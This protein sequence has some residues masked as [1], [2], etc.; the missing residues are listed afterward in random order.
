[1]MSERERVDPRRGE[2]GTGP[3]IPPGER[4][5]RRSPYQSRELDREPFHRRPEPADYRRDPA[6]GPV[7]SDFRGPP[8]ENFRPSEYRPPHPDYHREALPPD[9]PPQRRD[10]H[11][12]PPDLRRDDYS[13]PP[14]SHGPP[15]PPQLRSDYRP[16]PPPEHRAQ[17]YRHELP[18]RPPPDYRR[19][20]GPAD[21]RGPPG[22]LPPPGEYIRQ[23]PPP[24]QEFKGRESGEILPPRDYP[25][26]DREREHLRE[27]DYSRPPVGDYPRRR[28]EDFMIRPSQQPG[29]LPPGPGIPG[30]AS[31]PSSEMYAKHPSERERDRERERWEQKERE[32]NGDRGHYPP[33]SSAGSNSGHPPP[34]HHHSHSHTHP[35]P[36]PHHPHHHPHHHHIIHQHQQHGHNALQHPSPP[37]H[38]TGP[39]GSIPV[40]QGSPPS[41]SVGPPPPSQRQLQGQFPTRFVSVHAQPGSR[42]GSP[43]PGP[44]AGPSGSN[45][46]MRKDMGSNMNVG[47][48]VKKIRSGVPPGPGGRRERDE[49]EKER[50]IHQS[51]PQPPQQPLPH[52][53][54]QGRVLGHGYPHGHGPHRPHGQPPYDDYPMVDDI[55]QQ[56]HIQNQHHIHPPPPPHPQQPGPILQQPLPL[57]SYPLPPHVGYYPSQE[58][59]DELWPPEQPDKEVKSKSKINLGTFVYPNTPFP[60]YFDVGEWVGMNA[61]FKEQN[62]RGGVTKEGGVEKEKEKEVVAETKMDVDGEERST[63]DQGREGEVERMV[64]DKETEVE[65]VATVTTTADVDESTGKEKGPEKED[66]QDKEKEKEK[67]EAGGEREEEKEK[68]AKVKVKEKN[69][70]AKATEQVDAQKD[71]DGDILDVETRAIILIP[72]G[73][74]PREKPP[75]PHIWGGGVIGRPINPQRRAPPTP[76]QAKPDS[77]V[78]PKKRRIYTDDSDLF[79]CALHSGWLTW[80]ASARA[81]DTGKDVRIE[82]R[83]IRCAGTGAGSVFAVGA[84]AFAGKYAPAENSVVSTVSPYRKNKITKLPVVRKEE[85]VG[86]FIGGWGEKCFIREFEGETDD[87]DNDGRGLVSAGWGSGHDGSAIEVV[88]V[89]LVEVWFLHL[90]RVDETKLSR[91]ERLRNRPVQEGEIVLR[92]S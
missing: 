8:P 61:N 2:P 89:E 48:D 37:G 58:A 88:N 76:N 4:H 24:G 70:D 69:V 84:G 6:S 32:R 12:F 52:R 75:T 65:A 90:V 42:I 47:K 23:G 56:M 33:P 21:Y 22:A 26:R 73:Y 77:P 67:E 9:Y 41:Q 68:E 49:R 17:E 92:G 85:I 16:P 20:S 25:R 79:L 10:H 35:K 11:A 66:G 50:D 63:K 43:I 19:E 31:T 44:V 14:H 87:E 30:R 1:M 38:P 13:R 15:G 39:G 78:R 59:V 57:P 3:V 80:S 81:R 62:E 74:I 83:I 60:Y 64:V 53:D 18:P 72:N 40:G 45:R 55:E 46:D 82:V 28:D 91:R 7:P 51:Y 27:G 36:H 5:P 34:N 54:G 86:R 71:E 29:S